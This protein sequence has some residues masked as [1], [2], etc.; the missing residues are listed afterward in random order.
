MPIETAAGVPIHYGVYGTTVSADPDPRTCSYTHFDLSSEQLGRTQRY[1]C[2]G[3]T[4]LPRRYWIDSSTDVDNIIRDNCVPI[5]A[6]AIRP[7]DV[8]RYRDEVDVTTHTGRVWE[9]DA[10]GNATLIRSKWGPS[11][12]YLHLP[13]DVP[14]IYGT[15]RAYFRQILPL[16]GVAD[17]WIKDSP[18]DDGE[19]HSPAPWWTSPD[20]LVD[21]PPYDGAPDASPV[22][23]QPNRV[24]TRIANRSDLAAANVYVRY[25]WAD[26]SAGLPATAWHL[27]PGTP[28]HPNPAGPLAVPAHGSIDAP[29]VEWTPSAA[30]AH[31]CLL[32]VAYLNDDPRDSTNVDPLVYPF[33]IPWDNSIGQRNV[34]IVTA[35]PGS[36]CRL[37]VFTALPWPKKKD[38]PGEILAVLAHAPRLPVL[39][40]P[41]RQ[42]VLEVGV[43]LQG[44][45]ALKLKAVSAAQWSRLSAMPPRRLLG[46]PIAAGT[47]GDIGLAPGRPQRLD[48][49]LRVPRTAR[50][51]STYYLHLIQRFGQTITGGYTIAV[52]ID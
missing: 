38:V 15:Y 47:M 50:P 34:H 29:Y 9:T 46:T 13:A 18:A 28:G 41:T 23:G 7:G 27:I 39:G 25:Y 19:Q 24:W 37:T 45:R 17:L 43:T 32:A 49:D 5:A 26:P 11:A 40:Q 35:N 10:G 51:G 16:R 48:V 31:Q 6:G 1:N 21:V 36:A 33:E 8:V 52:V 22:F 44:K 42:V 3:F 2:W 20:I 4:F 14:S 12:E 30:P